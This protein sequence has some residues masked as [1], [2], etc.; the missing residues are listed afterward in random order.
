[1]IVS[2]KHRFIFIKPR[3]AASSSIELALAPHCGPDDILNPWP[4]PPEQAR[5]YQ[6]RFNPISELAGT[7]NPLQHART[8]RDWLTRPKFYDHLS[9]YCI[10]HRLGKK[11]WNSY[12]KFSAE[13][14]PWD[15]TVSHFFWLQ[16]RYRNRNRAISFRD[17]VLQRR[18]SVDRQF[19][20]D[21]KRYTLYGTVAVDFIIRFENLAEDLRHVM[22]VLGL[23]PLDE[24]P[25]DKGGVRPSGRHYSNY[26]DEP[27]RMRV[28]EVFQREIEYFGY[29]FESPRS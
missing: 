23:D 3:K 29:E 14:N 8:I 2:H 9:G 12:F 7:F 11:I 17:Y 15:K 20:T 25:H 24:L 18:W 13:R 27:A 19:P 16:S 5:N 1:M 21:W 4:V 22:S 6:G 26:Y 28:A 10:R